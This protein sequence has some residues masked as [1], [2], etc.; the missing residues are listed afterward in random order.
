M[1]EFTTYNAMEYRLGP[2]TSDSTFSGCYPINT[3]TINW[4]GREA[5]IYYVGRL[6][7]DTNL[8]YFA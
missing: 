6:L 1:I 4:I 3:T 2:S 7:T 5:T 8:C